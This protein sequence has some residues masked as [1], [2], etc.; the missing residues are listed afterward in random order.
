MRFSGV[1][2]QG[3]AAASDTIDLPLFFWINYLATLGPPASLRNVL[4]LPASA[5]HVHSV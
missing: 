1:W 3:V 2:L 4:F 5:L